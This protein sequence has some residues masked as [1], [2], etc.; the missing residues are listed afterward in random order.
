MLHPKER[1]AIVDAEHLKL[2]AIAYVV[3]GGTNAFFSLFGLFYAFMGLAIG[4]TIASIPLQRGQPQPPA[5]MGWFFG[6]FGL[7]IFAAMVGLAA[8][9]FLAAHRIR[10]RRSRT[11]CLV[12]ASV[13]CFGV[14]Y[15][16][17][18]GVW[19]LL[20]LARPTVAQ[21]FSAPPVDSPIPPSPTGE[22]VRGGA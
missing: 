20:V 2:L 13:T 21:L 8:L 4:G 9:K 19:T 11:L 17:A 6:A 7:A 1:Q 5:F 10:Q 22:G 14:P 15:G 12:I 16:T 3:A 18:L